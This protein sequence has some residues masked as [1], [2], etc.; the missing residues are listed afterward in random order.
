MCSST[1]YI[2]KRSCCIWA[3]TLPNAG[4]KLPK[5]LHLFIKRN[6]RLTLSSPEIT[7]IN[8]DWFILLFLNFSFIVGP[9]LFKASK[10]F[11][12]NPCAFFVFWR[13]MNG[14]KTYLPIIGICSLSISIKWFERI[15]GNWL[16][17]W[18]DFE[19]FGSSFLSRISFNN[20]I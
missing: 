20:I 12:P 8:L 14:S 9:M 16:L 1:V 15:K 19:L 4:M 6:D 7:S 5:I 18:I 10:R 3:T 13:R 11:A 2:W 17:I